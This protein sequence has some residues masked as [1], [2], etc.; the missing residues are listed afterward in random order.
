MMIVASH[1]RIYIEPAWQS[2]DKMA[3]DTQTITNYPIDHQQSSGCGLLMQFLDR[4]T[5]NTIESLFDIEKWLPNGR[6]IHLSIH[7]YL[8]VVYS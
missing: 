2:M 5:K 7:C 8:V 4:H 6:A 1:V 3:S